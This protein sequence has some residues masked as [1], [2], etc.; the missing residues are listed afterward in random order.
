MFIPERGWDI[1]TV[2]EESAKR[3]KRPAHSKGLTI[4][5]FINELMNPAGKAGWSKCD[6]YGVEVEAKNLH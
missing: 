1:L 2:R 5:G 3:V 6:M 4:D